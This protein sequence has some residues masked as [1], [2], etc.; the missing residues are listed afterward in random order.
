VYQ[1]LSAYE[2]VT[3]D[4]SANPER[5]VVDLEYL[6]R[7]ASFLDRAV[8]KRA[9]QVFHLCCFDEMTHTEVGRQ[10]KISVATVQ[11]DYLRAL[12]A[13]A[14]IEPPRRDIP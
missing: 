8:G 10:L 14:M 11:R 4:P 9:R 2:L 13:L 5:D 3:P 7:T 12:H 1:D 6:R